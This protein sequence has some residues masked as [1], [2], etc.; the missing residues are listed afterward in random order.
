MQSRRELLS[1]ALS[2]LALPTIRTIAPASPRAA[3]VRRAVDAYRRTRAR[4][5]GIQVTD[6]DDLDVYE[7]AYGEYQR[8]REHAVETVM[9]ALGDVDY[10]AALDLGD[11]LIVID[12]SPDDECTGEEPEDQ[13][14]FTVLP[15]GRITR[16]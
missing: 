4:A 2:T 13:A 11:V 14:V 6:D 16:V 8:A 5:E 3:D 15:K 12:Y 1:A 10:P 7:Q 9:A